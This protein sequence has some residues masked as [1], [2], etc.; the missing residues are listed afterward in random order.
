TKHECEPSSLFTESNGFHFC[1]VHVS[2]E[3][4]SQF[5]IGCFF[6]FFGM[7]RCCVVCN[8]VFFHEVMFKIRNNP[9]NRNVCEVFQPLYT[10][11][12]RS[13]I[14]LKFI[15]DDSAYS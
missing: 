1:K 11:G 15:N 8:C 9:K 12:K 4:I 10:G 3:M 6:L 5:V 13:D 7:I 14:P 2:F